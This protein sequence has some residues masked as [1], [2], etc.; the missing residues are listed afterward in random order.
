LRRCVFHYIA[1][2]DP[3]LM[4]DIVAVHHPGLDEALLSRCMVRFY[5]LRE[6]PQL[7]KKPST[8]ELIDWISALRHGGV[9]EAALERE[10]PFL[11]VLLK[12]ES[13]LHAVEK[14]L[15]GQTARGR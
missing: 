10:L 6:Q 2:P 1:F 3:P 15:L 5:W 12:K 13:D 7:R 4:R 8:S 9:S 14:V 11:G